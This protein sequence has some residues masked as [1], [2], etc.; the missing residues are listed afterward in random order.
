[1]MRISSLLLP[2]A[3]ALP[4]AAL[5]QWVTV[6]CSFETECYEAEACDGAAFSV[7]LSAGEAPEEVVMRS[8]AE[9]IIGR[10]TG[11]DATSLVWK[12]ETESAAHM[13]SWGAE[14][15]ARYSVH[16]LL[17]PEMVNYIGTCEAKN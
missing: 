2:L 11:S 7:D 13:I 10:T 8:A 17:G 12:A 9:T 4:N 14:G 6:T 3:L 1:M 16:L 15:A 5:A